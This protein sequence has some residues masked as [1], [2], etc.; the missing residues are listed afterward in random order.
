[1]AKLFASLLDVSF[2]QTSKYFGIFS[3][4]ARAISTAFKRKSS[5][6]RLIKF[7]DLVHLDYPGFNK[8]SLLSKFMLYS[9]IRKRQLVKTL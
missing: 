3:P 8:V 9:P 1:M 2:S 7:W 4:D 6:I 5:R